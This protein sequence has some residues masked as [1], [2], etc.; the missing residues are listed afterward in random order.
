MTLDVSD[1]DE[2]AIADL[3]TRT[4]DDARYPLSPRIQ[5]LRA[6]LAKPRPEP[7]R[8]PVAPLKVYE[9]PSKGRYRRRG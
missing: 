8:E 2:L 5:T 9:S 4:I 6:I 3:L 1:D 7:V